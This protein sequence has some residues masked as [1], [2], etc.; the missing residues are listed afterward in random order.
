MSFTLFNTI[1]KRR[2]AEE[3]HQALIKEYD[4]Y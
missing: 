1:K 4:N 3:E 2:K